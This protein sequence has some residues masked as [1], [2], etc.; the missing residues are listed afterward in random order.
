MYL[1]GLHGVISSGYLYDQYNNL[2]MRINALKDSLMAES[3]APFTPSFTDIPLYMITRNNGMFPDAAAQTR[4][5]M[6]DIQQKYTPQISDLES[7]QRI[8]KAQ[9][10]ADAAQQAAAD[11]QAAK[12]AADAQA[13]KIAAAVTKAPSPMF[14]TGQDCGGSVCP[15]PFSIMPISDKLTPLK[16]APV[17]NIIT[18]VPLTQSAIIGQQSAQNI[19]TDKP[20]I[21]PAAPKLNWKIILPVA[22]G[23]VALL[24]G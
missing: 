14:T 10:D 2:S 6:E 8:L 16:P 13:A 21:S 4:M 15:P 5:H 24:K 19:V 22:I 18:S 11:A 3:K 20:A 12:I 7:Q 23:A 9:I 17:E 1:S